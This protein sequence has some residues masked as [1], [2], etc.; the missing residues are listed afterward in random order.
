M[1]RFIVPAVLSWRRS[2]KVT[3]VR[4]AGPDAV[5]ITMT[6]SG[7]HRL[8]AAAGQFFEFRFLGKGL[9][10]HAHPFSLSAAPTGST[11]RITVRNLGDGTSRLQ[12]V[13]PGTRVMV[14]GPYGLFSDHTRS[15]TDGLVLAGAGIGIAPIRALLEETAAVPGATTVI[16]RASRPEELYLVDEVEALC[17]AKGAELVLAVGHR[18]DGAPAW[19]PGTWEGSTLAGLAP[20]V[21]R[22]DVYACGPEA[23]TQ[24]F[25]TDAVAAGAAPTRIHQEKFSW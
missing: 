19:L 1:F 4:P 2:L 14:E 25:V 20:Q 5:S 24:A 7:V 8:G 6:G 11:L 17:R 23:W 21:A 3:D 15:T 10:W 16:L 13:G 9:W 18:G 12:Q 22:A